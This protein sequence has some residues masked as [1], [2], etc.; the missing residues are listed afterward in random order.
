MLA[1]IFVGGGGLQLVRSKCSVKRIVY[2]FVEEDDVGFVTV[3]LYG[4][5]GKAKGA[6]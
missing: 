3:C 5:G 6:N 1:I 2:S 4:R